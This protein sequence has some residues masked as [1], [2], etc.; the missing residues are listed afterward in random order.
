[1]NLEAPQ[2]PAPEAPPPPP[3]APEPPS[4]HPGARARLLEQVRS[5]QRTHLWAEGSL[6]AGVL[7]LVLATAG[8]FVSLWSSSLGATLLW[9]APLLAVLTG[10]GFG[11]LLRLRRVGDEK[12]TARL[13]AGT[14]PE[15][16]YDVLAAVELERALGSGES[17]SKAMAEAFLEDVD[18][19]AAGADPQK[20]VDTQATRK[21][22]YSFAAALFLCL[23]LIAA[24]PR[25]FLAGL[26]AA[27]AQRPKAATAQLEPITGDVELTY[28]YPAHTGLAPRTV[29]GTNGEVAGPKGTEVQL[30]TRADRDVDQAA[31]EVNGTRVPLTVADSR[32]LAGSFVIDKE[33]KYRFVFLKSSGRVLV[34]G[35]EVPIHLEVDASPQV[36]LSAPAAELELDPGENVSLRFEASDDY[37]LSGLW[38]VFRPPGKQEQRAALRFDEGRRTNGQYSWD[39]GPLKL[40][41]G[42]RVTYYLEVKDNDTVDGPK[43]GVSRTQ[44]LKLYS[45][46]EH[47]RA[48]VKRAEELWERLVLHLADRLEGPD[49]A[50]KKDSALVVAA[51]VVDERGQK[52]VADF[53]N[54][55]N[56]LGADKDA[57]EEL[58][59]AL[60]NVSDGLNRA[61]ASTTAARRAYSFRVKNPPLDE[62][63]GIRL[64]NVVS[65]EISEVE[66]D[67]LFLEQLL[68]RQKML[69]LK[70]LAKELQRERRELTS[71]VEEYQKNQSPEAR[72]ELMARLQELRARIDELMRRMAELTKGIRDEHLNQEALKQLMEE[73][74]MDSM[75]D[76]VEK[77]LK[78]GK[79]DEALAKLQE[80]SMQLDQMLE[81]LEQGEE[82]AG[83]EQFPELAE[84]YQQFMEELQRTTRDQKQ[85]ADEAKAIRDRYKQQIK[86]RLSQRGA[87]LKKELLERTEAVAKDYRE[88]PPDPRFSR[89]DLPLE[90]AQAELE[91][92]RNAL[93]VDDF[94]LASEAAQRADE[95]AQQLSMQGDQMMREDELLQ[96]PAPV[97]EASKA[98]SQRLKKDASRVQEINRLLQQLFPDPQ[99]VLSAEEKQKLQQLAERQRQLQKSTEGLRQRMEEMDQM[100]PLF[101]NEGNQTMQQIGQHMGEAG[102]RMDAKDANRG[103]GEQK[104]ALDGLKRFMEQLKQPGSG[105]G[106]GLPLPM[107]QSR[108]GR[109]GWGG[110]ANQKVEIPEEEAGAAP[111][112]FRK[113]VLDAMKQGAPD[114]YKEQVKRYY[115]E[116][117]K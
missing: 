66:K 17:F 96:N 20:T 97:R 43:K 56:E 110:P 38:L 80:L 13:V 35:P 81:Q 32:S 26:S 71:L 99:S 75:L 94:D 11:V 111:K 5:R 83:E 69:D 46:A 87:A 76:K 3:P 14:L 64:T 103:H 89:F 91:N 77:S 24:W 115:E 98:A 30:R 15:L 59:A 58:V 90:K 117:V 95:A 29:A 55:A 50:Q 33:G 100:A 37:G 114:K 2:S 82:R 41:A 68:D 16:S 22:A 78:D 45:A 9:G 34:E 28:R 47:R 44:T 39:V 49:R 40:E 104:A 1:M 23:A 31:L 8:G 19:R 105:S 36:R 52:L 51:T 48:A 93:L 21:A 109:E 86:E 79:T 65:R 102:R 6:Y 85:A 25:P 57:P 106:K 116:L 60:Y 84:K 112:E 108:G 10:V 63:S 74:D 72:E 53:L 73:R 12:R 113:D 18:R 61:L 92:L 7:L 42:Q 88:L 4:R 62:A 107:L 70:E 101:G 54:V 27:F 67:I